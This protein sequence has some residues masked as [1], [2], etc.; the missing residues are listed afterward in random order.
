VEG[1]ACEPVAEHTYHHLR[2]SQSEL[3]IDRE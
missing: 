3:W 1:W 2:V